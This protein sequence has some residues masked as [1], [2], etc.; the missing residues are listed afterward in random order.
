MAAGSVKIL[1]VDDEPD[2]VETY[3]RFLERL[4]HDCLMAFDVQQAF[5]SIAKEEPELVITDFRLPDGDGFDVT[6][7]VRQNLP[8]TPVI[9]MTGYHARGMEEASRQAGAAAYLR[10]PFALEALTRVIETV[11]KSRSP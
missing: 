2:L 4:G 7:H 8:Q 5:H 9:V 1:L 6:R 10:K 11:L 3:A